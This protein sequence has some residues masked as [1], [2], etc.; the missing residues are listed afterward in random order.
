MHHPL[1]DEPQTVPDRTPSVE[2]VDGTLYV[3]YGKTLYA[4]DATSGE[5]RWRFTAPAPLYGY[6][7][8]SETDVYIAT[9]TT[10]YAITPP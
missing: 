2:L 8:P 5:E 9:E 1:P 3:I 10:L 4:V 6:W 7:T